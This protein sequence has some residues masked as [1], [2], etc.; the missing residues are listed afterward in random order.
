MIS[1][2]STGKITWATGSPLQGSSLAGCLKGCTMLP[3]AHKQMAQLIEAGRRDVAL[4]AIAKLLREA[5]LQ[6]RPQQV[7]LH[8]AG[9]KQRDTADACVSAP[10]IDMPAQDAL[11]TLVPAAGTRPPVL[12]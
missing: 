4:S 8:V 9:A 5:H 12:S 6:N 7:W 1:Q 3:Q 11:Q 2:H 10:C